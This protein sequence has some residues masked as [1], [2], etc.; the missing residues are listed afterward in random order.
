MTTSTS[1]C[2][3]RRVRLLRPSRRAGVLVTILLTTVLIAATAQPVRADAT[4][5]YGTNM[6]PS[7]RSVRGFSAGVGLVIVAFEFEY[8]NTREN[9]AERAPGLKTGMGNVLLQT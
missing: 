1:P 7:N 5:F 2:D 6:T 9:A 8:A 3:L 4:L